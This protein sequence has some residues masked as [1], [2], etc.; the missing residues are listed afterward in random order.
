MARK[1][2]RATPA[3]L[4]ADWPGHREIV[5]LVAW[6]GFSVADAGRVMR[7][8]SRVNGDLTVGT[9]CKSE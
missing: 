7:V 1:G 6:E 2:A 8:P 4:C 9:S 5:L 3:M